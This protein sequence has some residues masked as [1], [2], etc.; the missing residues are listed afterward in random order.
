MLN[1]SVDDVEAT[2]DALTAKGIVFEQ[3]DMEQLKTDA[4]GISRG[5]GQ[6]I[7]WFKDP[8]GNICSVLENR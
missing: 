5:E 1:L 2:V 6:V 4:K 7:A 8:A 3:Y